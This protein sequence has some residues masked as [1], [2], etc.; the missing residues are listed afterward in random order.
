MIFCWTRHA[1]NRAVERFGENHGLYKD[2]RKYSRN[3][4]KCTHCNQYRIRGDKAVYILTELLYVKT[5]LKPPIINTR[6]AY[7]RLGKRG[8][9]QLW[10]NLFISSQKKDALPNP[11][12]DL[13][14]KVFQD[15]PK[16]RNIR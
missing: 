7:I 5:I 2:L 4:E 1:E 11:F 12:V 8:S 9:I 3:I 13:L 16:S 6:H 10:N 15:K 14:E